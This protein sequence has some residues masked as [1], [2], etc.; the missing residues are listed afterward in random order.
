MHL[1]DAFHNGP[2]PLVSI[3]PFR[4]DRGA[5]FEWHVLGATRLASTHP[6]MF[7]ENAHVIAG[8]A[9]GDQCEHVVKEIQLVSSRLILYHA[10]IFSEAAKVKLAHHAWVNYEGRS[11]SSWRQLLEVAKKQNM[12]QSKT[13]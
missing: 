10:A 13:I 11:T 5:S 1:G 2:I 9:L 3:A 8:I 12:H 7:N 6:G 4:K